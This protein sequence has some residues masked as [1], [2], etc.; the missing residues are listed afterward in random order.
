M[1]GDLSDY[2]ITAYA[3]GAS[4]VWSGGPIAS[5]NASIGG[6]VT[7]TTIAPQPPREH[8][9]DPQVGTVDGLT[10]GL[11]GVTFLGVGLYQIHPRLLS[12][13]PPLASPTTGCVRGH[14]AW[15]SR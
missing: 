14:S 8:P 6:H 5:T 3:N 13:L 9:H 11:V 10:M 1:D 4:M 12:G 7:M 2:V 15:R